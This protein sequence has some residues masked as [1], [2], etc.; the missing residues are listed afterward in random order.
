MSN[1]HNEDEQQRIDVRLHNKGEQQHIDVRLHNKDEQQRMDVR[2]HNKDEQQRMDI[3]LQ[4]KDKR[5]YLDINLVNKRKHQRL[6]LIIILLIGLIPFCFLW[7]R[8]YQG[9]R[10]YYI[11]S[12]MMM[13]YTLAVFM[14]A[15]ERRKPQARE[16]VVVTAL[17]TLAVT[18]RMAFFMLPQF[19]PVVAI[20]IISGVCLGGEI[21]FVVGAM[22]GFV[23]N[24]FFGQGP[25]T[26]WQMVA[27]GIIGFLAGVLVEKGILKKQRISLCIFGA[28]ATFFIYG[29]IMNPCSVIMFTAKPT[30]EAF[31]AAYIS[32]FWFDMIHS[33][34]TVIFLWFLTIPMLQKLER[35]KKKYGLMRE[36]F[37]E[38]LVWEEGE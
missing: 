22:T 21:G 38:E 2:L 15:F 1:S 24:F 36:V 29:G 25:W 31:I 20:V 16:I 6:G 4:I 19:K 12:L 13:T 32:G 9:E 17:V 34:A 14:S 28:C 27:F 10:S 11:A 3:R 18:G 30:R 23:S 35:V 8:F 26:Q 7:N 5:Q 33:L 37:Q